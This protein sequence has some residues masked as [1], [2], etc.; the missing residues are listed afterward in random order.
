MREATSSS[1]IRIHGSV[2]RSTRTSR[3][4]GAVVATA[5][6]LFTPAACH[7]LE[8]TFDERFAASGR[9]SSFALYEGAIARAPWDRAN[10]S[11]IVKLFSRHVEEGRACYRLRGFVTSA[12]DAVPDGPISI[13]ASTSHVERKNGTLRQSCKRL[14]RLTYA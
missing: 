12:K 11:Q 5:C 8:E 6:T 4:P 10:R 1:A 3:A 2:Q 7:E 13:G 9:Y 14:T